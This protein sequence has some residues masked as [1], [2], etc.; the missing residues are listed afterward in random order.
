MARRS[1]SRPLSTAQR[2]HR[3]LWA[4]PILVVGATAQEA[5][6]APRDPPTDPLGEPLLPSPAVVRTAPAGSAPAAVEAPDARGVLGAQDASLPP[7]DGLRDKVR[8]RLLHLVDGPVLRASSRWVED[9]WEISREGR[10]LPLAPGMVS[11]ARLEHRVERELAAKRSA[12]SRLPTSRERLEVARWCFDEGLYPEGLRELDRLL[13]ADPDHVDALLLLARRDFPF[14]LP[15]VARDP[16]GWPA[17]LVEYGG[18]APRAIQELVIRELGQVPDDAGVR[19]ELTGRLR[20][21]R[22]GERAFSALALR[23]LDPAAAARPEMLRRAVLDPYAEVRHS[24]S[25]ALR[26]TGEEG[27]TLPLVRALESDSSVLRTHAARSLGTMGFAAAVEPLAVRLMTLRTAAGGA[28][29]RAPASH[30]YVGRQVSFVQDFETEIATGAAIA[31]PVIGVAQT[32]AVLD[33]R[34]HGVGGGGSGVGQVQTGYT[35]ATETKALR[36]ALAHI[37]RAEVK[38]T[39]KAWRTWWE[40]EGPAWV[41]AHTPAREPATTAAGG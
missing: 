14:A 32:G 6:E 7:E 38:D 30:I 2:L 13:E 11:H 22:P 29:W 25:L 12:L 31:K 36:R 35:Y 34:V 20:S 28:D 9:H 10:W 39:N 41:A 3:A 37:T 33:A 1:R 27:L 18:R 8:M 5:P 17:S 40:T 15:D 24:A 23:R 19:A 26:D 4:V 16:A 21:P